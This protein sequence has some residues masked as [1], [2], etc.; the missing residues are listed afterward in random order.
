MECSRS[1]E[2]SPAAAG[3]QM[4]TGPQTDRARWGGHGGRH[5]AKGEQRV[6]RLDRQPL[7]L[8][9]SGSDRSGPPREQR[10]GGDG[11]DAGQYVCVG[12]G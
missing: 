9:L 10:E 2:E 4:G 7:W 6:A 11:G 1:P 3:G 5:Q 12:V 8:V